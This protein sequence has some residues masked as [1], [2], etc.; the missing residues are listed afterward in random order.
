[1][2]RKSISLR[3]SFARVLVSLLVIFRVKIV[4]RGESII[5]GRSG[6]VLVYYYVKLL[7]EIVQEKYS[8]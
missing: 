1:M 3:S 7:S 6:Q 2:S 4:Y 8:F 5:V